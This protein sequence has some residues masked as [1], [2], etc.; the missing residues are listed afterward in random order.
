MAP[1]LKGLDKKRRT[2]NWRHCSSSLFRMELL[3][4][5]KGI[6]FSFVLPPSFVLAHEAEIV[7]PSNSAHP[8]G[9]IEEKAHCVATIDTERTKFVSLPPICSSFLFF[10]NGFTSEPMTIVLVLL[11]L[12]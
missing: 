3:M 9:S 1:L 2:G 6:P 10:V 11:S 5:S 4:K 8:Q 7:G 12:Q